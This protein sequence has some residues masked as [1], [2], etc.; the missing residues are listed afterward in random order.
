VKALSV[1]SFLFWRGGSLRSVPDSAPPPEADGLDAFAAERDGDTAAA[2]AQTSA[3]GAHRWIVGVLAVVALVEAPVAGLWV[4]DRLGPG[5]MNAAPVPR[6]PDIH[7][8]P[9]AAVPVAP[10]AAEPAATGTAASMAIG[11]APPRAAAAEPDRAA[12]ALTVGGW[13]SMKTPAPMQVFED[14]RL[15]GTTEVDRIMLPVG[16]HRLEIVSEA[17]GYRS[18]QEVA[19][20]AGQTSNL[21]LEMPS[22]T[23]AVNAL[24]W[25]EVWIDGEHVGETPLGNLTRTIGTHE[26]VFRHPELGEKKQ[27]ITVTLREP[28]RIGVDLRSK[29]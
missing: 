27:T 15:V 20:R 5:P 18:R 17:L 26:V 8:A 7:A 9:L 3:G 19:I 1:S 23:L 4:Y 11:A 22:G 12:T 25:A 21:R 24:P 6:Q 28:A 10:D 14:G 29:S 16:T 2:H 13:V